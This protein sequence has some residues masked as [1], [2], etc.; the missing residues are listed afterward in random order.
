ML[1]D[2][3]FV[4]SFKGYIVNI[5]HIVTLRGGELVLDNNEII[6]LSRKYEEEV[7]KSLINT[8]ISDVGEHQRLKGELFSIEIFYI[9]NYGCCD[10]KSL[11][12]EMAWKAYA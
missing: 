5:D 8:V 2:K 4:Y 3:R 10:C 9:S 7:R 1:K 6:P 11:C 12:R